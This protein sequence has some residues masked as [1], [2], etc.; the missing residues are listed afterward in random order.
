MLEY[1]QDLVLNV[2]WADH[3][4]EDRTRP[5]TADGP[6]PALAYRK[7]EEP[8]SGEE[9][10]FVVLETEHLQE[11]CLEEMPSVERT[12]EGDRMTFFCEGTSLPSKIEETD[13]DGQTS[14]WEIQW[15][16]VLPVL[17]GY[18][19]TEVTEEDLGSG[20]Y[21][22]ADQGAGW[23]YVLQEEAL[24]AVEA[25]VRADSWSEELELEV[26]WA[27]LPGSETDR[28]DSEGFP[29]VELAFAVET[30]ADGT[31]GE[32]VGEEQILTDDNKDQVGLEE[33]P[34]TEAEEIRTAAPAALL[35]LGG[36]TGE[37]TEASYTVQKYRLTVPGGSLPS[38]ITETKEDG[39]EISGTVAW[40]MILPQVD[41][42]TLLNL[43]EDMLENDPQTYFFALEKG[44]GMYYAA[45]L[46]LAGQMTMQNVGTE[47]EETTEITQYWNEISIPVHWLDNNNEAGKRPRR[48]EF[49]YDIQYQVTK[50]D[51]DSGWISLTEDTWAGL[52]LSEYDY[53]EPTLTETGTGEWRYK[54]ENNVLPSAITTTDV[55]GVEHTMT[56][57][58]R[59]VP[60][61]VSGY[62]LTN[63]NDL[64]A[65]GAPP[66]DEQPTPN[67]GWYYVLLTDFT[68]DF[69]IRQG[70]L[71]LQE[72]V[73]EQV[74]TSLNFKAE[75][76]KDGVV[77][78]TLEAIKN[79]VT[80]SYDE[81]KPSTG[82]VTI[83][84]LPKYYY[85]GSRVSYKVYDARTEEDDKGTINLSS[86]EEDFFAFRFDNTNVA[87]VG[88]DVEN[89]HDGGSLILTL[90]GTTD[91]E[92]RK[93]WLD[94]AEEDKSK[95]PQLEFELWRYRAGSS[96]TTAAPVRNSEGHILEGALDET[97]GEIKFYDGKN[98]ASLEKYDA[99]GYPYIYVMREYMTGGTNAYEQVMG[100]VQENGSV[101]DF[102]LTMGEDG[103]LETSEREPGNNFIYCYIDENGNP[104]PGTISNR[105]TGSEN[106]SVVKTWESS[107]F[108]TEFEDVSV[109]LT[110][111]VRPADSTEESSWEDVETVRMKDFYA[112]H[113]TDTASASAPLYGDFGEALEY[114]WIETGVYQGED[115]DENLLQEDDGSFV[116]IQD[117]KEIRYQSVVTKPK[118]GENQTV[119]TNSIRDTIGY[120]VEKIWR[121]GE[122]NLS[123]EAH[124]GEKIIFGLYRAISG[125]AP[126]YSTP[127]YTFTM[128]GKVD[129]TAQELHASG[130]GDEDYRVTVQETEPWYAVV[131]GLPEYDETGQLYEYFL[132]ETNGVS[133]YFPSYKTSWTEDGNYL[134]TVTN[135]PGEGH[136][137]IVQKY[138]TDG[139]DID[140]REPVTLEVYS[141]NDNTKITEVTL[142][143]G[144]WNQ[145]VGIGKYKPEEV[146]I[147]E[148]KVGG[149]ET[150]YIKTDAGDPIATTDGKGDSV[151]KAVH[152][153]EGSNHKYEATYRREQL[154]DVNGT[155]LYSV[156]NRRLGD[157]NITVTKEWL[158]GNGSM[159]AKLEEELDEI[160]T[161]GEEPE[162]RL[163]LRLDFG[164][165]SPEM[166][167]MTWGKAEGDTIK[168]GGT[169]GDTISNQ[170][171]DTGE[172]GKTLL[173][174]DLDKPESTYYFTSL[175]KYD[176]HGDVASYVVEEVWVN[177]NN[178]IVSNET[179]QSSYPDLWK[180]YSEYLTTTESSYSVGEGMLHASD[181]Q[182]VK[183]TNRLSGTK[184]VSWKK[185]W[186][187]EYTYGLGERPDI[188]LDVYQLRHTEHSENQTELT[189]FQEHYRWTQG[190]EG[191]GDT[192]RNWEA[193]FNGLPKY[194][195]YGYEIFYYAVERME[196]DAGS[197]SYQEVAYSVPEE[198]TWET[199]TPLGTMTQPAEA[200]KTDGS[201]YLIP[202]GEETEP[203]E[204]VL[205]EG[206]MFTNSIRGET[207]VTVTKQ[208]I[209][210]PGLAPYEDLPEATFYLYRETSEEDATKKAEEDISRV[211]AEAQLTVEKDDWQALFANGTYTFDFLYRGKNSLKIENGTVTTVPEDPSAGEPAKLEKFSE[212]GELY[213]YV[214]VEAVNDP[215]AE[216]EQT[217]DSP[218]ITGYTAGNV[219]NSTEG[220]LSFRKWLELP[221]TDDGKVVYPA[222]EFEISRTYTKN[223]DT[224]QSEP[225]T[226]KVRLK[227]DATGD[228]YVWEKADNGG[229]LIWSSV[230]VRKKADDNI[231]T[232]GGDLVTGVFVVEGLE[233]Y[234]PN[235]SVY[236]YTVREVKTELNGYSTWVVEDDVTND[237]ENSM[238]DTNL[239]EDSEPPEIEVKELKVSP[240]SSA[241]SVTPV[242][243]TFINARSDNQVGQTLK[244]Q[245]IWED[246]GNVLDIRPDDI[247]L[248]VKRS[249]PSQTGQGNGIEETLEGT[250]YTITW[251][252][253][254]NPNI[255]TYTI[256]GP[257]GGELD[258]Y[259]PNG[260]EWQYTVTEDLD[261]I[262]HYE[263]NPATG[264]VGED[265][266][267]D[268]EMVQMMKDLTNSITREVKF[269]KTWVDESGAEITED[270]LGA[271]LSVTF[272][273]QV[274]A[275]G[276][277]NYQPA[278]DFFDTPQYSNIYGKIK[279]ENGIE[280]GGTLT[281]TVTDRINGSRWDDENS[282]RALPL[283]VKDSNDNDNII[284]L[285]YRVVETSIGYGES[286][287]NNIKVEEKAD[288]NGYTYEF[289]AK[290]PLSSLFQPYYPENIPNPNDPE[291]GIHRQYNQLVIAEFSV[292]KTWAG[293]SD[294]KYNT[295]TESDAAGYD[296]MTTFVIQRA[297]VPDHGETLGEEDWK[298]VAD[299]DNLPLTVT[300]YGND[301]TETA[302]RSVPDLPEYGLTDDELV[303]YQYR[304]RE[305]EP[306]SEEDKETGYTLTNIAS[307]I[308]SN[309]DTYADTYTAAY[310]DIKNGTTVTNT[311]KSTE[312]YAEKK[313]KN[314]GGQTPGTSFTLQ[315]LKAD[316]KNGTWSNVIPEE[317]VNLD[318]TAN[319]Q[320]S[321]QGYWEYEG[322]K[323]K[324]TGL[325][326]VMPG[327]LLD[328]NGKTQ[329]QVTESALTGYRTESDTGSAGTSG[330]PFEIINT[331]VT[332]LTVT[333]V[334]KTQTEQE[335]LPVTVELWRTTGTIGDAQSKQVSDAGGSPVTEVLNSTNNW[336][337]TFSNLPKYD[338]NTSGANE[339]IYYVREV[340]IGT[341]TEAGAVVISATAQ[342]DIYTGTDGGA[343]DYR[344]IHVQ[345]TDNQSTTIYNIGRRNLTGTKTWKDNSDAYGTRPESLTLKLYRTTTPDKDDSWEEVE[346]TDLTAEHA[347]FA[348][349]D[350]DG[351]EWTYQYSGLLYADSGGDVYTYRIE[352]EDVPEE[353]DSVQTGNNMT[354]TLSDVL[355]ITVTKQW[356]D[357]SDQDGLRPESVTLTLYQNGVKYKEAELKAGNLLQQLF[358]NLT[359]S[360][361]AWS[362]TF[363]NLPEY[364]GNGVR[365]EYTVKEDQ[366]PS[367][368]LTDGTA[369]GSAAEGFTV[370]NTL[371]TNVDVQKLWRGTEPGD[372]GEVVVG[373]Y[374]KSEG[375]PEEP[376]AVRGT[377]GRPL[378][379]ALNEGNE[380]QAAFTDLPRF[381]GE[382]RRY[383]Y[384][385]REETVGGIP[386]EESG[387][388]IHVKDEQNDGTFS[389]QIINVP[390]TEISGTKTWLDN[391]NAGGTRPETLEL[392]IYRSTEDGEEEEVTAEILEAD[393]A[394][395]A[396][397][398]TDT[399]VWTYTCSGLPAADDEGRP[400]T[401]RVEEV[402]PS[403]YASRAEGGDF[404]NT[405]T[406]EVDIFI[407]KRWEDNSNSGGKRPEKI[408]LILYANGTEVRRV[409]L[410]ADTGGLETLWNRLTA[411]TDNT[412]EYVFEGL[413]RYDEY[414]AEITYTVQ[415]VVPEGYSVRYEEGTNTIIN[416]KRS[417]GSSGSSEDE[418]AG[419][420][421]STTA[422][423]TGPVKTGDG[424][425]AWLWSASA[426]LSAACITASGVYLY[427]RRK[428]T[429]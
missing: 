98:V 20:E 35:R 81:D 86:L 42:Y 303:E 354:N 243:G 415:E 291:G 120:E 156:T 426:V 163:M 319:S 166:Y 46:L 417:S 40:K 54:I 297:A 83:G 129:D 295:R 265:G 183:I 283:Y 330:D 240:D 343:T 45:D 312:V 329:Y 218:V 392:K 91:Y 421:V 351:D 292:T 365:Y 307:Y 422:V 341:G 385:V 377:D 231:Q 310:R 103:N 378:T 136:N 279:E 358:G 332:S 90:T 169:T 208:W 253:D 148:T 300:V 282:F 149:H 99:E 328:E 396:W 275:E 242:S 217:Y 405:L 223:D 423:R 347:S 420:T 262:P 50:D 356:E 215:A 290:N 285:S 254:A 289:E 66:Y 382:G 60:E 128:D 257:D 364:D 408:E 155:F 109:E 238:I 212:D 207:K 27:D 281:R 287:M 411:G 89:L 108:Q 71:G 323:A 5:E 7:M 48:D 121:D 195:D 64:P 63:S 397:T 17:E 209:N 58:W 51:V 176:V 153:F 271:E 123:G 419:M 398:G 369:Q 56:L 53:P 272:E 105:L 158:D 250:D 393:G 237:V 372:E 117:G 145:W 133:S 324:W 191:T 368:Y 187:D 196:V 85:D 113:L 11:L 111:Q 104:C 39:G 80:I 416:K 52:G 3:G 309:N 375:T 184:N 175:P 245:K 247:I 344:V 72:E 418:N 367:G 314:N 189:L 79:R 185:V 152:Q 333:K 114:R 413:P 326:E 395:L 256:T 338:G 353:Y 151:S 24:P 41:G 267:P 374:R 220:S 313:W 122:G 21:A 391:H 229:N 269:Q 263:A 277:T 359:G 412:W 159:R 386:A 210:M 363:K 146:Y 115:S 147:V 233:K 116:L 12:D 317:T 306:L 14:E 258:R 73:M 32:S 360:G 25:G 345:G 194:D 205:K 15:K 376:A 192:Y 410:E 178:E 335:N 131:D 318:G 67:T 135:A 394:V 428:K 150:D 390:E 160:N 334:W 74:L 137:I 349:T 230:Q 270:Y 140:H 134:T 182:T 381:D 327:S 308:V 164:P 198:G 357:G 171:N 206:N 342:N 255:W 82:T 130:G 37:E 95:R 127:L 348:W 2:Y 94:E 138:W 77:D 193:Y 302:N 49:L 22:Y 362:Y 154:T 172:N 380:W 167:T 296:W 190:S 226:V 101:E 139:S 110:L 34:D 316:G 106:T 1:A 331:R 29:E 225:E 350:T 62:E 177:Q 373:L 142:E 286:I 18:D 387:F 76:G 168:L 273:L 119:I 427:R 322:W 355:D 6:V 221:L 383:L 346:E 213:H 260:M 157:V 112:E 414:G 55:M 224:T 26:Y 170:E 78:S 246:L 252:K 429:K 264:T 214:L 276:E 388:V 239:C 336:T 197:L 401:Y 141:R 249:A 268:D 261:E 370:T 180:I 200:A 143:N 259:A 70:E 61:E 298:T 174:I 340:R 88:S 404:T 162:L 406:A 222:V 69:D 320:P 68:F 161:E 75:W 389:C 227:E 179:L 19:L 301:S 100:E 31:E 199:E 425:Q 47:P 13:G 30:S 57:E 33:L 304:A 23:Y 228:S 305:L 216:D 93:I 203:D 251:E 65:P 87:T 118:P 59:V 235:G 173:E 92:A 400:Y 84:N 325:P 278:D 311:M 132:L 241:T 44:P 97:S 9:D 248:T 280:E 339:Y 202:K 219:Y 403:G 102:V 16:Y 337:H 315:Y 126:D 361:N 236:T 244:G 43:T 124:E 36:D 371:T 284:S 186:N 28:P 379:L 211:K 8:V 294:N 288:S 293:D 407:T 204:Y 232:S 274:K 424:A 234:A 409:N 201:V 10:G 165:D 399:D 384:E 321:D 107:V 188:Y 125:A 266:E 38:R 299:G 181:T 144:I 366:V 4:N 352:E 96:Y 402:V